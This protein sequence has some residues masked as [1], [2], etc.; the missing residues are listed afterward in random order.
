M[1]A[2]GRPPTLPTWGRVGTFDSTCT[3]PLWLQAEELC[4]EFSSGQALGPQA[5]GPRSGKPR[6]TSRLSAAW[7]LKQLRSAGLPGVHCSSSLACAPFPAQIKPAPETKMHKLLS[8]VLIVPSHG[9]A[10]LYSSK[11]PLWFL[12]L[13][14]VASMNLTTKQPA[15]DYR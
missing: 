5:Q 6:K 8:K 14:F 11:I 7:P 15:L 10:A 12:R 3:C 9:L 2:T 4:F 1:S 13:Q